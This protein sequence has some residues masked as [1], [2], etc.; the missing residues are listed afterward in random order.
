LKVNRQMLNENTNPKLAGILQK[1]ILGSLFAC[2][3]ASVYEERIDKKFQHDLIQ[4]ISEMNKNG[5]KFSMR[6]TVEYLLLRNMPRIYKFAYGIYDR[7][8]VPNYDV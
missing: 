3:K 6:T 2:F 5:V 8:R 4:Q 1:R 7:I